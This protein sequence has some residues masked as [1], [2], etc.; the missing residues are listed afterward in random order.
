MQL[1]IDG[2]R[3]AVLHKR[4]FCKSRQTSMYV[5]VWKGVKYFFE[6]LL[7]YQCIKSSK[8]KK[9]REREKNMNGNKIWH[10]LYLRII[11]YSPGICIFPYFYR[12]EKER[13]RIWCTKNSESAQ[14]RWK[15]AQTLEQLIIGCCCCSKEIVCERVWI[16]SF[17]F[18]LMISSIITTQIRNR[19]SWTH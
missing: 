11:C 4:I 18:F 7:L 15:K 9:D 16:A 1:K 19:L 13:E 17:D 12:S 10:C 6:N 5:N 14:Q 8:R 2:T 3:F